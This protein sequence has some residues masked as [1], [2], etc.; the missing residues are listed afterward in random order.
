MPGAAPTP[1]AIKL[2]M[3]SCGRAHAGIYR[4]A[5]APSSSC[6]AAAPCGGRVFV[7]MDTST[8]RFLRGG[9]VVG[10]ALLNQSVVKGGCCC[11]C[12]CEWYSWSCDGGRVKASRSSSL[13]CCL[14]PASDETRRRSRGDYIVPPPLKA[15]RMAAW[16]SWHVALCLMMTWLL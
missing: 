5:T 8:L 6:I 10:G 2:S 4:G 9:G 3:S 1:A 13:V 12:C 11:C 15:V 16:V 14:I 7:S